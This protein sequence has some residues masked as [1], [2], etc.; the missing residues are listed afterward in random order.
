MSKKTLITSRDPKGRQT[1]S[2]FEAAY[3]DSELDDDRAQK[4]NERSDELKEGAIKL[5]QRLTISDQFADE[6]V[7]SSYGY[8][9]GY[10]NPKD[11]DKQIGILQSHWPQL[12]PDKVIQYMKKAHS[13]LQLPD[14]I[15]G[16]FLWICPGFFSNKHHEELEEILKA[17]K[18]DRKGK[19]HNHRA[20][21]LNADNFRQYAPT[22]SALNRIVKQQPESDLLVV[23]A[24]FGLHGQSVPHTTCSVRRV[25]E[26]FVTS[27]FGVNAK[28]S[29]TMILTHPERL[30]DPNDLWIDCA[31]DEFAPGAVGDFSHAPYFRL[32]GG[33]VEFGAYWIDY[34][35]AHYASV[36]GFVPQS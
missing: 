16:L 32:S 7:M 35:N 33:R 21:Q 36:S 5:I 26:K 3:N 29:G 30:Q 19:F 17:I 22:T 9:S 13:T 27:E 2:I 20:G 15:E 25:R 34:P 10:K 24:Q 12:N 31:G 4:L 11:I 28:D 23:P 1:T 6:E 14:W 8:L 18:K